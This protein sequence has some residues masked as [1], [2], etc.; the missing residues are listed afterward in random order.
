MSEPLIKT[1]CSFGEN[2]NFLLEREL[3]SGG[4]GGVYMGRDKMLDRPVAV[5]VMLKEL[6]SDAEFVE[7]FKREAQSVARLIHPNIAQVYSY[8]ICDGMPYMAMEL[9]SGGSLYSLM[10]VNPGKTDVARVMKVCQ[11][12]AQALQCASDQG[13]VHGDVKPE[14]ILFDANGNAKLVDFGLAAMQKDTSEIWGTPYYISPEKVKKEPIDFRADMYSLGGTLYHALTGVAPF[15]GEDAIAVVKKRFDGPPKKPSEIRPELTPAIDTLVLKMLALSKDDRYPSFEALLE[16]FKEVLT[17]GL[18]RKEGESSSEDK[19]ATAATKT[20]KTAARPTGSRAM[21]MRRRAMMRPGATKATL[22]SKSSAVKIKKNLDGE[23]PPEDDEI[24]K[25]SE[26]EDD[27]EEGGGNLGLK[28][29][30]VVVGIIALIGAV[31]G[32]LVWYQIADKKARA[33][34]HQQQIVNGI[35]KARGAIRDTMANASKFADEFDAFAERAIQEVEKP[36]A[37][38]KRI[39]PP[40]EAA[41]LKPEPTKELL[42]AIAAT[43]PAPPAVEAPAADTNAAPAAASTNAS[44]QAATNAPPAAASAATNA[45]PAAANAADAK[46]KDEKNP[47]EKKEDAKPEEAAKPP[48]PTVITMHELWERAYGCQASAIR[49]R[50]SIRKILAKGAEADALTAQTMEVANQLADISRALVEMLE[51][52]KTSKDVENVRKGITY[53]KSKGETT[54]QQTTRRLRI[55]K[56]EAERKARAEANA[57]AEKERQER[58]DAERKARVEEEVNAIQ[59]KFQSIVAQGCFRQLDWKT[60]TRQLEQEKDELKTPEGQIAADLEIRKVADM[61]KMHDIFITK[62]KGHVFAKGKVLK[63]SKVT[64][65]NEK[66]LQILRKDGKSRTKITWQ[67]F[68]KD[69][70]GNLNEL[71]NL[72]IINTRNPGSK[73]RLNLR[74]WADAMSGAALTM[75]LVCADV[76][77]AVEKAE[78]LVLETVKQFPEYKETAKK[79]FPDLADKFGDASEE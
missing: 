78:T 68:Y 31:I 19:S 34:E 33:E 28:V 3:G 75:Q 23:E 71:M 43:N 70:P 77:G 50:H 8:G 62:L 74:E 42:D 41:Q 2:G 9:A 16:A 29:V 10:T 6:G 59:T 66:E 58:I 69:Y 61:K 48:S 20:A 27:E 11:Q 44:P 49:I 40:E 53:I 52:V 51:Q 45:P 63:G 24:K 39:L 54:I 57:A 56:L 26:N 67:K 36:T 14:N 4:M 47:E 73:H 22:A 7:K 17:T 30:G 55:E 76:N 72:Y 18:T 64:D 21:M 32:G 15:E 5:K 25:A 35:A 65:V 37:E 38:L 46:A 13:C 60:A 79:I 1:P 12:V